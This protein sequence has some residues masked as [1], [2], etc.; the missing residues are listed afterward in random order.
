M[1]R[2]QL[3]VTPDRRWGI[4]PA[5]LVEAA[6][7]RGFASVGI[8]ADQVDDA[9]VTAY[10]AS[11]ARCHEVLALVVSDDAAR[12]TA[13]AER[14]AAAASTIGAEWVLAVFLSPLTT[15]VANTVERCAALIAEAG[16]GM[17]VEFSPF[18]PIATIRDAMEVVQVGNRGDGRAGLLI[19]SWHFS[20]GDSTW[21]DLAEVPLDD[22]AYVQF[23]D[24]LAPESDDLV[25]E[26][27]DRRALP[28]E[29]VLELD[30]FAATLL[31]R[32]WAGLVSVEVLSQA[33][34][35]LPA[36]ELVCRIQETTAPYWT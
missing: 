26:T 25:R 23:T 1:T 21:D 8:A 18:G 30:R 11:G 36:D 29:G 16:A 20:F 31:D 4:S 22:L 2:V 6:A 33:L 32:G 19:D 13:S 24:A 15:G 10:A 27:M 34:Q 9:A 12:T 35:G 7:A 3:A 5:E 14:R 17:A 28:G